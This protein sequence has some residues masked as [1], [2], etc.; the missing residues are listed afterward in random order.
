VTAAAVAAKRRS[1]EK[2]NGIGIALDPRPP[3]AS[4]PDGI[5]LAIRNR[6]NS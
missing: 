4:R 6:A 3:R 1:E 5:I 2:R